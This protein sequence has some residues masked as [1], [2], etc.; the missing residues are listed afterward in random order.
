MSFAGESTSVATVSLP[1]GF[2]LDGNGLRR[3]DIH[4][5]I[6]ERER[7]LIDQAELRGQRESALRVL[8]RHGH[9]ILQLDVERAAF[10]R[11]QIAA[12]AVRRRRP[13]RASAPR[14]DR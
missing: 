9:L 13:A 8:L 11:E 14:R 5:E 6:G 4:V 12:R 1:D 10:E 3:D 7:E 2:A